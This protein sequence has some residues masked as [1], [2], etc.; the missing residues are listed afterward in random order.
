MSDT[1]THHQPPAPTGGGAGL[2]GLGIIV[3]FI[4]CASIYGYAT[5]DDGDDDE[6]APQAAVATAPAP[7]DLSWSHR[8][9]DVSKG[10]VAV[11][12]WAG[13]KSF[14]QGGKIA[15]Q[16]PTGNRLVDEPGAPKDFGWQP[17]GSYIIYPED[18]ADADRKVIL[19]NQWGRTIRQ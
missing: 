8:P 15:I 14:P 4:L 10:G 17:S 1:T 2:V 6:D 12:L 7:E 19:Y 11:Y 18:P 5:R 9:F 13:W 3:F 16:T